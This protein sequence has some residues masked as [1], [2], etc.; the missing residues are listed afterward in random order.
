MCAPEDEMSSEEATYAR[1][2]RRKLSFRLAGVLIVIMGLLCLLNGFGALS[3]ADTSLYTSGLTPNDICGTTIILFGVIAVAGGI[4]AI[5]ARFF[6]FALAANLLGMA[7]GGWVN[8]SL[9]MLAFVLLI[10]AD[11]D[12]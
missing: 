2:S 9:G 11:E 12:F 8:F 5:M 1:P 6:S 3:G 7:G 4:C 10:L